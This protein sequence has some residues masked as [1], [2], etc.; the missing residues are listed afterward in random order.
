MVLSLECTKESN[1]NFSENDRAQ[2]R[3]KL[4]QSG[5][6]SRAIG[7]NLYV[8]MQQCNKETVQWHLNSILSN[9]TQKMA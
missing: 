1:R 8:A 6:G 5:G 3:C 9:L 2:W 4:F 7:R